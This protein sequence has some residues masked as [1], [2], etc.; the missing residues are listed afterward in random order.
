MKK[1]KMLTFS[2]CLLAFAFT[3]NG[4]SEETSTYDR[5]W[6]KVSLY[7]NEQNPLI[8]KFSLT[9]KLQGEYHSFDND[10]TGDDHDD[11]DWRRFRFG[12]KAT[13][14][15]DITFHSEA[16]LGLENEGK[17]LYNNLTD[18]LFLMVYREWRKN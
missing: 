3:V 11:Y 5:L 12:F 15:G 2:R 4:Q 18:T 14:F 1:L 16:D 9:G 8:R 13:L 17:P 7:E 6:S 10:V